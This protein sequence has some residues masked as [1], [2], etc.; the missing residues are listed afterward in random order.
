MCIYQSFVILLSLVPLLLELSSIG[1]HELVGGC[2]TMTTW[3]ALL[4]LQ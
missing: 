3:E 1:V 4:C 2:I